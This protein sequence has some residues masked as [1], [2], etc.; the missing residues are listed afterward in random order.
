MTEAVVLAIAQCGGVADHGEL[1]RLVGR[2]RVRTA[3]ASGTILRL[4]HGRY[5]LPGLDDARTAAV[6]LGGTVSHRSAALQHGWGVRHEPRWPEVIV[7]RSRTIHPAKRRRVLVRWRDLAAGEAEEG[8]TSPL[9]TVVDCARDLSLEESLAVADSALRS[10]TLTMHELV[11][12]AGSIPHYRSRCAKR[13]L[14]AASER[15]ANPFES[16]LRALCLEAVPNRFEAQLPVRVANRTIHPDIVC[17]DLGLAVEADSHEFHTQRSQ[18]RRDCWRY[19]ELTLAGWMV[20][21]FSW[22]QVMFEQDWVRDVIRRAAEQ[23]GA[24]GAP[25]S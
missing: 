24:M 10:G 12:A 11:D 25:A 3:M 17:R 1:S 7:S 18:L 19:A 20:L 8:V 21:R 2:Q 4:A 6:E 23:R 13:A 16:A 9:R 5:G 14:T 15:A 22:E